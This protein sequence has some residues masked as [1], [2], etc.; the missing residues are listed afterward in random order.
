MPGSPRSSQSPFL[1]GHGSS[2]RLPPGA[3]SFGTPGG[4]LAVA[5]FRT[6]DAQGNV[7]TAE[8]QQRRNRAGA[9]GEQKVGALLDRLAERSGHRGVYV[10]HGVKMPGHR[11][12][13]DHVL[14]VGRTVLVIDT[15]NWKGDAEY[16]VIE[17]GTEVH[18]NGAAFPGGDGISVSR[19]IDEVRQ[20][21]HVTRTRTVR[22]F[23]V[24]ANERAVT[25]TRPRGADWQLLNISELEQALHQTIREERGGRELS[26]GELLPLASR[27]VNPDF[28][29]DWEPVVSRER[30][31]EAVLRNDGH[32]VKR[33]RRER[34]LS[35]RA[36]T[37]RPNP[38]RGRRAPSVAWWLHLL[39]FPAFLWALADVIWM[40]LVGGRLSP[41]TTALVGAAAFAYGAWTF[42]QTVRKGDPYHKGRIMMAIGLPLVVAGLGTA[43]LS[44]QFWI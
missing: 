41:G 37:V 5:S 32:D 31:E 17:P 21:L 10:F 20:H 3:R 8:E 4:S 29:G 39:A 44:G 38:F 30:R 12:D 42:A 16:Q 25:W 2:L 33:I 36:K 19:Y 22:G 23:L 40:P 15:K 43:L 28:D 26:A 11:G 24:I 34:A 14:V 7:I 13:V 9:A 1:Y 18:R 6:E 27:V 35:G